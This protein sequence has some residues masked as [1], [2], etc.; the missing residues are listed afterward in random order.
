MTLRFTAHHHQIE[1][2]VR[3]LVHESVGRDRRAE[4]VRTHAAPE[5]RDGIFLD[6]QQRAV[7]VGPCHVGFD[8]LD[9]VAEQLARR[10]VLAADPELAT[11]DRILRIGEQSVVR[12]RLVA[13]ELKKRLPDGQ[14]I[15]I[16]Q[17]D[18]ARLR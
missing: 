2:L 15:A 13:A 3:L 18:F 10:D 1:A 8:V 12:A 11:S 4:H 14:R 5:Q 16:E 6:I 9:H 7:V 17:Q